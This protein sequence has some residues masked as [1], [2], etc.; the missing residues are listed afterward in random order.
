MKFNHR[1][2]VSWTPIF[3]KVAAFLIMRGEIFRDHLTS[4]RGFA[5]IPPPRF[6][7]K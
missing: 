7:E 2:V 6:G 3:I 5:L 1:P 4:I